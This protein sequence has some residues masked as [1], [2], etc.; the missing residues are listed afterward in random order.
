[1]CI[2]SRGELDVSL[3]CKSTFIS[4]LNALFPGLGAISLLTASTP[5]AKVF[6]SF[7]NKLSWASL[8]AWLHQ[9]AGGK[10]V[11]PR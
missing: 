3:V 2:V 5:I 9:L 11:L 6:H 7:F 10:Y 1:M 8:A 4:S